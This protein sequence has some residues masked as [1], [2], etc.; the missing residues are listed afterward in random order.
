MKKEKREKEKKERKREKK[1]AK[2]HRIY[3]PKMK[4]K[5]DNR[6]HRSSS[7][8]KSLRQKGFHPE[9]TSLFSFLP[10][11]ITPQHIVLNFQGK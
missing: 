5:L 4:E 10:F 7:D 1:E 6:G 3:Y 2:T 11:K 9:F 8:N